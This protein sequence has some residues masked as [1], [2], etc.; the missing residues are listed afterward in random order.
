[1]FIIFYLW[2]TMAFITKNTVFGM[3]E[4]TVKYAVN[5]TCNAVR[6]KVLFCDTSLNLYIQYYNKNP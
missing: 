1:M 4:A 3:E 2:Q 6:L 5:P